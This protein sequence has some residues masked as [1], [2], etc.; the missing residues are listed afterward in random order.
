ML[1]PSAA[2]ARIEHLAVWTPD[3]E[4][5]TAWYVRWLGA[6][7]G[8]RYENPNHG[9]AS[10]FLTLP[11]G[12]PRFEIMQT[13]QLDPVVA[14]PGAQRMGLTHF[15]VSLGSEAAVDAL[16]EAMRAAGVPVLDA[17]RRTGDGY[18]ESVVMDPDGT[19]IE[20]TA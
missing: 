20:L 8:D 18:Y 3:V 11:G 9:F 13:T 19:R 14:A 17:P 1:P 5:L 15:A 12:G 7:A 16:T 10:R 6:T 2:S 4:R